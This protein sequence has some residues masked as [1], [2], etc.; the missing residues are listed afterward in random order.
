MNKKLVVI[1]IGIFL[2][3]TTGTALAVDSSADNSSAELKDIQLR[4][5]A[6]EDELA[7]QKD[8]LNKKNKSESELTNLDGRLNTLENKSDKLTVSGFLHL[9]EQVW[10]N[11]GDFKHI[12]ASTGETPHAN[13]GHY[14]A[15]GIDLYVNYKVNDKWAIKVEDEAVRD[16]RSGGYWANG[17]DGS[18]AASQHDDQLYA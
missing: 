13:D 16:F 10:N 3:C 1:L 7:A 9:S 8:E 11:S 6:L 17:A 12:T 15:V 14:P 18:V 4:I 5:K 2:F